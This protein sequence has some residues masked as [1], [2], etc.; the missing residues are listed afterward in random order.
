V[1][2]LKGTQT[3]KHLLMAFAGESQARNR[4]TYFASQA[5][6]DGFIQISDL[7]IETAEQE[8]EHAKRLF[9]FMDGGELE[10]TAGFPFG[11]IGLTEAN[12]V[13]SAA[14]E[15][16]EYTEMYPNFIEVAV[17]EGFAEIGAV[18]RNIAKAEEFHEKRFLALAK[19]I[20]EGRVF[21]SEKAVLWRCRNY[22]YVQE[23]KAAPN[24][25][26]ACDHPKDYFE[27]ACLQW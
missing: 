13:A 1:K 27:V 16:H 8:K 17:K 26:P 9:K 18:M 22:G 24:N 10:I 7:F 14:G 4:Y 15:R 23:G 25:C 21:E 11:V 6:K 5:K 3:A 19:K 20:K 12:L 2:Q